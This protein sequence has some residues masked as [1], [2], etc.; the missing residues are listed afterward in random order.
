MKKLKAVI[1]LLLTSGFFGTVAGGAVYLKHA[2]SMPAIMVG[3]I[4]FM[5]LTGLGLSI[6]N[7]RGGTK[8]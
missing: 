2:K 6:I 1:E 3:G 5:V 4:V 8:K 7:E